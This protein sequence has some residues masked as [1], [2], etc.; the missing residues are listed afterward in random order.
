MGSK[1]NTV[2]SRRPFVSRFPIDKP[3]ELQL[4]NTPFS[5]IAFRLVVNIYTEH[6]QVI[7]TAT[8]LTGHLL[9]TAKHVLSE[10]MQ[11]ALGAGKESQQVAHHLAALQVLPGPD[12]VIWDIVS[13]WA[14]PQCDIALLHLGSN[15]GRSNSARPDLWLSPFVFP[16]PP[17]IDER[18]AAFGYRKSEVNVSKNAQ[19]GPHIYI[20][21]EP[22]ISVG[23]VREVHEISRD[24]SLLTF[25]CYRVSA[26]FDGGM[27]GGPVFDETGSLCGIVCAN[28]EGAHFDGEPISYVSTLWP[29]FRAIISANRGPKYPRNMPYPVIE[30]ARDG[31]IQVSD[32][33]RLDTWFKEKITMGD[34]ERVIKSDGSP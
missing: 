11:G 17:G 2:D 4:P 33:R 8:T 14:D 27:S 15:P 18:V 13:M 29:I 32:L 31:Q 3:F 9:V 6:A 1:L 23:V 20:N 7:G 26:R 21:D 34:L 28:T 25:P 24:A 30:L 19:G 22:M 10:L 12:Y 16:F 5:E